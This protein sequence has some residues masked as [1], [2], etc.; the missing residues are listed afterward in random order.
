[1]DFNWTSEQLEL[2]EATIQFAQ[3]ELGNDFIE[4]DKKGEF[5][6]QDWKK[7]ASHGVIGYPMPK[8][9]GGMEGNILD[10][11]LIMEGLGYGF[12]D[13]ALIFGINAQMWSVQMP[14]VSHG[15]PYQ[16]EKYL[17]PMIRGEMVGGH[18]MSEPLSGS[19]A[20]SLKTTAVKDGNSYILNGSKTFITNGP[21]S[22]VYLVF[23][24]LAPQKGMWGVTA[25]LVEKGTEGLVVSPV[26]EKM[27][28]KTIPMGALE[29]VDCRVPVENRLGAEGSGAQ[30]FH[31]SMEWE[32]SCILASSLGAMDYQLE[33]S[34]QYVKNRKQFGHAISDFQS[35]SNRVVDM[36]VR[37]ETARLM[38]YKVA[39]LKSIGKSAVME[40]AIAKLYLSE[41]F[42]QSSLDSVRIHGANGYLTDFGVEHELRDSIGG[43]IY[44]GTSDIQR[45]I[46]ARMLGL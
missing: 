25:F 7:I 4:R 45:N 44:S 22:D 31:G 11:M 5:S 35:V 18:C 21:I 14:I 33:N 46:I 30:L 12:R 37:I 24:N 39:W 26:I 6:L 19:D 28:L 36:K 15:S 3:N 42:V 38:L 20:Y 23:A 41:C 34:I 40:A 2:K 32:R 13:A 43:L 27:G 8:A 29:L 17:A 1:M 9:Y 10:T 16:K